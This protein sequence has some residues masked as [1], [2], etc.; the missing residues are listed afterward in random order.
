MYWIFYCR[1]PICLT[2]FQI[3]SMGFISG[4]YGG[5]CVIMMFPEISKFFDLCHA[6]P[7]QAITTRSSSYLLDSSLTPLPLQTSYFYGFRLLDCSSAPVFPDLVNLSFLS[8]RKL[9]RLWVFSF[10]AFGG[11]NFK[12]S[13]LFT[14][15]N[16]FERMEGFLLR[17]FRINVET[18]LHF[19]KPNLFLIIRT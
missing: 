18:F 15:V 9:W 6:A 12:M 11:I 1:T 17:I 2:C 10:L 8:T 16:I 5:I 7:S 4:T 14:V 13:L 3:C 19:Y